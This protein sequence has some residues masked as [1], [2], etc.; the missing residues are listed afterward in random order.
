MTTTPTKQALLKRIECAY[1]P[2]ADPAASAAWY[3][4]V[5]GL[6]LRSPVKPGRGAIMIMGDGQWLFL[7]PSPG[8]TPLTFETTGWAEGDEPF[9]MFPLCFET[10]DIRSLYASLKEAGVWVEADIR[11]EGGCGLQLDFKDPDGNKF[12][13]WQRPA[14]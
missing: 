9:E 14:Q 1:V 11:D 2:V 12:Q 5:L 3:E 7:L 4:R 6:K 10:D 8:M 13:A